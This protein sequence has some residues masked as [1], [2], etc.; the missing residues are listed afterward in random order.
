MYDY[1]HGNL[2]SV[3]N[4]FFTKVSQTDSY[5]TRLASELSFCL[6]QVRTNYGKFRIRYTGAKVGNS[7]DEQIKNLKKAAFKGKLKDSL[8]EVYETRLIDCPNA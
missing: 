1:H 4:L 5:N 8:L 7:I 6:P 3:F 2:P